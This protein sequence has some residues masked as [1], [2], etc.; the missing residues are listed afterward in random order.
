[1]ETASLV[2]T[3]MALV[4]ILLNIFYPLDIIKTLAMTFST[5]AYHLV[6]RLLVGHV[7]HSKY[8]NKINYKSKWFKELSF[9]KKLYKALK[10]KRLK[11]NVPTYDLTAFDYKNRTKEE[12]IMAMCQSEI[13]HEIIALVSFIPLLFSFLVGSF[14]TFFITS[15]MAAFCDMQ[16]AII[17]RYNRPRVLRY[18]NR[19]SNH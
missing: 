7:I 2:V 1:M 8:K 17:Q 13:V 12:I 14:W 6:I 11:V 19:K 10:V 5:T 16:F 4:S 15:I 9:E 18:I 3:I